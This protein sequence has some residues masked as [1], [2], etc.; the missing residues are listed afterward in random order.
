MELP[1][2]SFAEFLPALYAE[3]GMCQGYQRVTESLPRKQSPSACGG[4]QAELLFTLS[5]VARVKILF[6]W[7]AD[8]FDESVYSAG[9]LESKSPDRWVE[10]LIG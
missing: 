2:K 5:Q 7:P 8:T 3:A 1:F 9:S 6:E 10:S 4:I